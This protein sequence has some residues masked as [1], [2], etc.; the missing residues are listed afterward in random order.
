M[1]VEMELMRPC[2]FEVGSVIVWVLGEAVRWFRGEAMMAAEIAR[3]GREH[4]RRGKGREVHGG[5][6]VDGEHGVAGIWASWIDGGGLIEERAAV[7]C[8]QVNP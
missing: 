2:G 3:I 5:G 7:G 1:V 8:L 6:V 4:R